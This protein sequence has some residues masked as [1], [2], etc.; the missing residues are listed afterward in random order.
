MSNR[1]PDA[2]FPLAVQEGSA[3]LMAWLR[4]R[5]AASPPPCEGY[6]ARWCPRCGECFCPSHESGLFDPHRNQRCPL[7]GDSAKHAEEAL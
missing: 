6:F 4:G 5:V 1:A 7:H 2:D 3:G